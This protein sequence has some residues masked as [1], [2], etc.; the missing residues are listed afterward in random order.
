MIEV[1][2]WGKPFALERHRFNRR[3][4]R[5]YDP[6]ANLDWKSKARAAMLKEVESMGVEPP[7][8]K[9]PVGI[10]LVAV[11][12]L[13]DAKHRK[14]KPVERSYR[15]SRPDWSNILKAVEDA[16]NGILWH[17]DKQLC[18]FIGTKLTGRQGEGA[19]TEIVAWQISK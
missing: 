11:F 7:L 1:S 6:K 12:K 16:G 13:P 17:D 10:K 19:K 18:Q 15:T 8:F 4:G 3:T 14:R 9:G 5:A 2:I